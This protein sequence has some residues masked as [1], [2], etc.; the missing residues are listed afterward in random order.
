[1]SPVF[2]LTG[3]DTD[4]ARRFRGILDTGSDDERR[5]ARRDVSHPL[6]AYAIANGY[7]D[8]R[9]AIAGDMQNLMAAAYGETA[10]A[11]LDDLMRAGYSLAIAERYGPDPHGYSGPSR[12]AEAG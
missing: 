7:Q 8:L 9:A 12:Y 2:S 10:I 1:M 3:R 11:S 6:Y 4:D 5:Q